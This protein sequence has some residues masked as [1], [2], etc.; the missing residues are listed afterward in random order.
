[1]ATIKDL[2]KYI[3]YEFSSGCYT[4][5][6]Y[7]S[8][9]TK[10]I[11]FLRSICKQNHWQLVNVG[12]NHYCFS[13]FIKSAENKCVYVSISDVR[14]FTNEWYSNI[15]IRTAKNEQDYHGGFNHRT[16][17]KE[18]EMKAMEL[19]EDLPFPDRF[20]VFGDGRKADG[21]FIVGGRYESIKRMYF[22][23]FSD[24]II[25]E[26][27]GEDLLIRDFYPLT[28]GDVQLIGY[29]VDL[30]IELFQYVGNRI[31]SHE[32]NTADDTLKRDIFVGDFCNINV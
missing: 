20:V 15:L 19:L 7:K 12:R 26:C 25:L 13:A 28:G 4:G 14:F 9:Q 24:L 6:D 8:F 2:E 23:Y 11:N 18:L 27:I 16:T 31:G 29:S 22:V 32:L 17:L 1:M 30:H 3:D 5:D 10:Y 21:Y